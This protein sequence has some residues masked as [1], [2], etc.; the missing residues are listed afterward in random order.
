MSGTFQFNEFGDPIGYGGPQ[1]D[2]DA[3]TT[4]TNDPELR[5][6][7]QP[8]IGNDY[9][10]GGD[11]FYNWLAEQDPKNTTYTGTDGDWVLNRPDQLPAYVSANAGTWKEKLQQAVMNNDTDFLNKYAPGLF[12]KPWTEQQ[13]F[14]FTGGQVHAGEWNN[15]P[16]AVREQALQNPRLAMSS[17]LKT[18]N[19][20]N[21]DLLS[22]NAGGGFYGWDDAQWNPQFGISPNMQRYWA[23]KENFDWGDLIPGVIAAVAA[24]Y[25]APAFSGA[26]AA[27]SPSLAG[28]M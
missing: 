3:L 24:P 23:D 12:D 11:G 1:Y 15:L 7:L 18:R 27:A 6:R 5:Q 22:T 8:F 16:Q 13:L 9:A 19:P 10:A 17:L 14:D 20:L 2:R 21:S 26:I 4:L 25:M 28:A